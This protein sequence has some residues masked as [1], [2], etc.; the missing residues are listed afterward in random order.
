M[1]FAL[2]IPFLIV[3]EIT[4]FKQPTNISSAANSSG[5]N[6]DKICTCMRKPEHVKEAIVIKYSN[7]TS[8]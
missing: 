2:K 7:T 8:K 6:S 1:E 3:E 5:G 4:E